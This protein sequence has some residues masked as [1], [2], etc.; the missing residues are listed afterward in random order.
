ME[1]SSSKAGWNQRVKIE[2]EGKVIE[3]VF[4]FNYLLSLIS[5][6]ENDINAK[7]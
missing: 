6:V 4:N 2:I 3:H 7:L 5:N 1:R